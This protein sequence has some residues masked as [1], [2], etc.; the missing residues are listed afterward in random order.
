MKMTVYSQLISIIL[1][2]Y[3]EEWFSP[4]QFA[5]KHGYNYHSVRKYLQELAEAGY[6][7]KAKHGKFVYYRLKNPHKLSEEE[8]K[9]MQKQSL[10]WFSQQFRLLGENFKMIRQRLQLLEE[11]NRD[12]RFQ[13]QKLEERYK[14]EKSERQKVEKENK[15]LKLKLTQYE[16]LLS[17]TPER[18]IS[19]INTYK[20]IE[21]EHEKRLMLIAEGLYQKFCTKN[22]IRVKSKPEPEL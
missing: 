21:D 5:Q 20:N 8:R 9:L 18:P 1:R 19:L 11:E 17:Q 4:I 10:R 13:I 12:L 3:G 14:K 2:D 16:E 7:E 6:L 22:L 15:Q